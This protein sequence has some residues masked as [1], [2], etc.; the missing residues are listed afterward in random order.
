MATVEDFLS[1]PSEEGL[2]HCTRDQLLKIADHFNLEVSDKR[3]KENIRDVIKDNLIG[4][5]VI[6]P[7]KLQA[8]S[9]G[10]ETEA[11]DAGL[12]F[13]QR[14]ELLLL[15]AEIEQ[16]RLE[17]KR[18]ELEEHRLSS[19]GAGSSPLDSSSRINSSSFDVANNLRLVPQFSEWDL[20]TFFLTF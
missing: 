13:E 11:P 3:S 6:V 20:D 10:L 14:R 16:K 2:E 8:A 12:T 4:S 15:Q 7:G 19:I 18:L 1:G 17:V 9:L 5:G